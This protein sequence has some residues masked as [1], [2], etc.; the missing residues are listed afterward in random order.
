M[1]GVPTCRMASQ[2]RKIVGPAFR[3]AI[4]ERRGTHRRDPLQEPRPC[5]HRLSVPG[6]R[7]SLP[8]GILQMRSGGYAS[9]PTTRRDPRSSRDSYRSTPFRHP[10]DARTAADI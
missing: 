7:F 2:L 5:P 4:H 8:V 9:L 1:P 6:G 10:S 3:V